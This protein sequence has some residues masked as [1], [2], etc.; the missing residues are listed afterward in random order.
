MSHTAGQ[1]APP[2]SIENRLNAKGKDMKTLA[3]TTAIA[4]TLAAPAA[5]ASEDLAQSMGVAT[6]Q[7]TTAQLIELRNA[8]EENDASRVNFILNGHTNPVNAASIYNARL[9]QAIADED[10]ATVNYLRNA[11]PEAISTQGAGHSETAQD[12]FARISAE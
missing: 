1:D 12:I 9:E 3:L 10:Y 11:G 8:I 6:G 4:A 7:Y 5:F 2:D